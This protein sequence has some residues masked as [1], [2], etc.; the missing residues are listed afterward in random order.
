LSL[1]KRYEKD[2]ENAFP[3]QNK[4]KQKNRASGLNI[5]FKI[6]NNDGMG[7]VAGKGHEK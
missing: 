5:S 7:D 2:K 1:C 4:T 3:K 6:S